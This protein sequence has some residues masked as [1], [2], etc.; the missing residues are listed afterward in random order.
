MIQ[1][2]IMSENKVSIIMPAFNSQEFIVEAIESVINQTYTNWELII[3][4]DCSQDSTFEIIEKFSSLDSRISIIKNVNNSGAAISRNKGINY[5]SGDY[6][7]FL[8]S[9]DIWFPEKLAVQIR[10]MERYGHNFT[11]TSYNKINERG[12]SLNKTILAKK[13]SDHW[14]LLKTCPGNSTVI[15]NAKVL[16]KFEIPDFKKRNDYLM[17]LQIIKI[18]KKIIG[19]ERTLTSHRIRINSISSNKVSLLNYHWKIY[20]DIE[21]LSFTKSMYLLIYW[22]FMTFFK[23]R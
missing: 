13:Y 23:L 7:A 5:A 4:D 3:I 12:E 2:N 10:F 15:Y 20:R 9:D 8:D 17:W 1:N 14:G 6:I 18:E 11:C 19:I 22:V 21:K 16:G